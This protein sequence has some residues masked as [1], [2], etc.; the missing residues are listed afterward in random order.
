MVVSL[1]CLRLQI[2]TKGQ[3]LRD[4]RTQ[5]TLGSDVPE[6]IREMMYLQSTDQTFNTL[7]RSGEELTLAV[8]VSVPQHQRELTKG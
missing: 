4:T 6:S 8:A 3:W 5:F 1:Q 2:L 7:T